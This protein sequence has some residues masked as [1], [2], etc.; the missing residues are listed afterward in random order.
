M[1]VFVA[2]VLGGCGDDDA[3][4]SDRRAVVLDWRAGTYEGVRLGDTR[5]QLVQT[6]GRPGA[7][8]RY[9][10]NVPLGE[11]SEEIGSLTNY[12]SPDIGR[13]LAP[14][15]TLRYQRRVFSTTGGSVT[16]WGTT[17]PRARTPEGVRIG[18][19]R[20]VVKRRYPKADCFI[21]NDDSEY[22]EY[23]IC[24][25]RVCMGRTLSFGG[26]PIKSI[27]LAAESKAGLAACRQPTATP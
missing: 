23:P 6:L 25:I 5:R 20:D 17:D 18:D 21:Q 26:D 24:R 12:R 14:F 13:G 16:S 7:R 27:Y 15:E 10:P 4:G 9:G 22:A 3:P 11:R 19:E 8:G 2:A 1:P